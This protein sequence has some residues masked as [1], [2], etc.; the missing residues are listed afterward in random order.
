VPRHPQRFADVAAL[1]AG[2]GFSVCR[3][4]ANEVPARDCAVWLGDSMGELLGWYA[5]ADIAFV[6]GSL[7]D[8]G[9]QNLIEACAVGT[10][11]L[12][13]PSTFNFAEAARA[14]V[15]AKAAMQ[16][17]DAA[18]LVEEGLRLL[19][20]VERRNTM[21]EAGRAFTACHRGATARTMALIE[22]VSQATR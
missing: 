6:G 10:P 11:V 7:L 9:S 21:A 2:H 20:D 19:A 8:Y 1:I 12:I 5:A 4:S 22:H 3:R 18:A 14:A 13:G 16:I 15:K 17:P